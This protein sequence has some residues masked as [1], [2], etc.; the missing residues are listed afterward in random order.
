MLH[1]VASP[2]HLFATLSRAHQVQGQRASTD[3]AEP[4]PGQSPEAPPT[5]GK[6]E[7]SE[8]VE[9]VQR[10]FHPVAPHLQ[11]QIDQELDRVIVRIVNA[12]SGEMIR[13][14]PPDEVIRLA[15]SL[16]QTTGVLLTRQA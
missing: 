4:V 10:E 7:L 16:K 14:I 8:A 13:Q 2:N 11:F 15:K 3:A 9:Q 12:Q 5:I 1:E 6:H